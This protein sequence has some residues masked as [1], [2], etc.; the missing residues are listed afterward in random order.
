[1]TTEGVV[2]LVN[3]RK[4]YADTVALDNVSLSFHPGEVHGV[5]GES[6]A[7]KSVLA[8]ILEGAIPPTSGYIQVGGRRVVLNTPASAFRHGIA[9][10]HQA[11]SLIPAMTVGQNMFLGDMP[12][13][14]C[15]LAVDRPTLYLRARRV[16]EDFGI[17]LETRRKVCRLGTAERQLLEIAKAVARAPS[18][19]V[20][21]DP[22][23]ALSQGEREILFRLT[24]RLVKQG[25]AVA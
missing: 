21:D 17:P 4:V 3:L 2:D 11:F 9:T 20:L 16:L 24:R 7:G 5:I 18:L 14:W 6:G 1:M 23:S 25:A 13:K 22:A 8:G 15:G 19:L 10:V 12:R